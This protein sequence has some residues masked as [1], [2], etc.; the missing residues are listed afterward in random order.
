MLCV[1]ANVLQTVNEKDIPESLV[2]RLSEERCV[3]CPNFLM[4]GKGLC[5][6]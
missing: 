6:L 5:S 4:I 1:A 2:S 3:A